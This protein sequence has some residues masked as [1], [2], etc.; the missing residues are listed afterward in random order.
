MFGVITSAAVIWAAAAAGIGLVIAIAAILL[1]AK[2]ELQHETVDSGRA[3]IAPIRDPAWARY[4]LDLVLL[5]I[6]ALVFAATSSNGYQLVLAP[7]GVPAISVSYWALAGP[8]LLWVGAGL[9]T[10][11]LADLLIGRGRPMIRRALRPVTGTLAGPVSA[12]LARRRRPLVR[13]IVLLTLAISF[14]ASTA[15]FNATYAQQA[16]ADARLTN[17]ADVTVVQPAGA[18]APPGRAAVIAAVPGV[19]GVEPVLHR[20]AYIGSDLQDLYGV[21]PDTIAPATT[22]QDS[23]F[24]G[25]TAA[26]L[27]TTLASQ[28]DSILV[29][30]ETVLDYQLVVGDTVNLRLVDRRSNGL[31]TVPFRYVGVVNEFPTAPRDSFFVANVAYVAERT[32]DDAVGVFLVDTGRTDTAAVAQRLGVT[33]GTTAGV[34][35]IESTRQTVGSSLTAVDLAGLTRVELTFALIMAVAAGGLVFGLGL[36]E[37]RRTFAIVTALGATGRQLR[38]M[39]GSEALVL[40]VIGL[41]AGAACAAVLSVMLV[42]VLTD[43][44]DPPPATLAI[45]WAYLGTVTAATIL[46]LVVVTAGAVRAVRRPAIGALREL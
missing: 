31:I 22:L 30:A 15:T 5:A 44:F 28:P 26:E 7:E 39:I 16:E 33:L 14:A 43:V 46:A 29:S 21:R 17:G 24:T 2:R 36:A 42:R 23:Y 1:P 20:F 10:W 11:R 8:T 6:A 37:R 34:T 9:L 4:G 38:G 12:G 45:P 13:A 35:D 41:V 40:A 19:T 3:D 32:G 18:A 25:G 27:M